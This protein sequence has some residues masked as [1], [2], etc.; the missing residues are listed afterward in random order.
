MGSTQGW[1]QRLLPRAGLNGLVVPGINGFIE[2]A[3]FVGCRGP[4]PRVLELAIVIDL[5]RPVDATVDVMETVIPRTAAADQAC[6][7]F[8]PQTTPVQRSWKIPQRDRGT[9]RSFQNPWVPGRRGA[10]KAVHGPTVARHALL[11]FRVGFENAYRS[12]SR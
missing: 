1:N 4:G 5:E 9:A 10:R 11:L 12:R 8:E 6:D 3:T 2:V 7:E